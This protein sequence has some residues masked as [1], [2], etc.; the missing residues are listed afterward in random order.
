MLVLDY[1]FSDSLFYTVGE[2][3]SHGT[4]ETCRQDPPAG[5]VACGSFPY[6]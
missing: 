2:L 3:Q 4:G 5:A 6:Q 1:P